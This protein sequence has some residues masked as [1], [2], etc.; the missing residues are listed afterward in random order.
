MTTAAQRPV[1]IRLAPRLLL[2]IGGAGLGIA[3]IILL[4]RSVDLGQLGNAFATVN[5]AYL[6]AGIPFYAANLLLKVPRWGLLFG[7]DTPGFDTRFGAINVGYAIN[8]LLPAR[9]GD[10]IRAYWVRDRSGIGM[11]RTLSTIALER[12]ADG[13]AVLIMLFTF[14]PTVAF[15]GKLLGPALTVGAIFVAAI[16]AMGGLAYSA[17]RGTRVAGWLARLEGGRWARAA[18]IVEQIL[19]GLRVLHDWRSVARLIGYTVAI[20]VSNA[21]LAW[22]VIRAFHLDVPLAA[23]FLV[24]A[25][26][27]LG[28]AVPSS[29]GYL[30]VFDYLMVLTLQLYHVHRAPA[31]AAALAFHAVAFVPVTII[32]VIYLARIGL[33][34]TLQMVRGS[35]ADAGAE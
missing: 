15:P 4:L 33:Q 32:G 2:L 35:A 25:V 24:T 19:N 11:V 28:M 31:L 30:G 14:A 10:L 7:A 18:G 12:V 3:L 26:L 16:F 34:M 17:A 1:Y 8:A 5:Y 20:W 6:L 27:N 13:L 29:P 21:I 23:G 22:L 9:L